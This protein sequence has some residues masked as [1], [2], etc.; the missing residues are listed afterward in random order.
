MNRYLGVY[1]IETP[2][3]ISCDTVIDNSIEI[4][5]QPQIQ[6]YG[7]VLEPASHYCEQSMGK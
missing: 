4:T 3:L 6:S 7:A 2:I 5:Y 1:P